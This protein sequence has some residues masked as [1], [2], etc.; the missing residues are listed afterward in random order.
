MKV[1]DQQMDSLEFM[2][3]IDEGIMT[4]YAGGTGDIA[5]PYLANANDQESMWL[6]GL[7]LTAKVHQCL[8][9]TPT[10]DSLDLTA[11]ERKIKDILEGR[12]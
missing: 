10:T 1:I 9:P 4:E 2:E 3:S 11:L 8:Q 12:K 6:N 7:M 5:R